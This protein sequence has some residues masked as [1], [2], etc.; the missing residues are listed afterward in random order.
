MFKHI[1]RLVFYIFVN[2]FQVCFWIHLRILLLMPEPLQIVV[3]LKLTV[4]LPIHLELKQILTFKALMMEHTEYVTHHLKKV[5]L[6]FLPGFI[7]YLNLYK[8][9]LQ[10][11]LNAIVCTEK[12][13]KI[14]NLY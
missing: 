8:P 1:F 14:M 11:K 9:I 2:S 12:I 5:I 10:I 3:M 7:F 13:T 4:L 6:N